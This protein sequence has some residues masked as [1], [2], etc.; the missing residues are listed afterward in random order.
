MTGPEWGAPNFAS[1]H[2]CHL[3]N[4]NAPHAGTLLFWKIGLCVLAHLKKSAF[5]K[6]SCRRQS[7]NTTLAHLPPP[8]WAVFRFCRKKG[9]FRRFLT[10]FPYTNY[11][12]RP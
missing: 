2:I 11:E 9:V 7:E 8:T 1:S 12:D 4:F 5:W 6:A 3:A 10:C